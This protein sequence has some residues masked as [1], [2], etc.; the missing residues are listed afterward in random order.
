MAY[1]EIEKK[2][3]ITKKNCVILTFTVQLVIEKH[4]QE[5]IKND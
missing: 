1:G 4:L 2:I 5:K 3:K